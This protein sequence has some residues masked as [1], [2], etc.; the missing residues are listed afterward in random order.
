M[1]STTI[2]YDINAHIE[3]IK[4]EIITK[5]GNAIAVISFKNLGYG[6]ITAIKFNAIGYNS[7][8][9]IVSIGNREKFFL[10]IQDIIIKKNERTNNLKAKLPSFDIRKLVLEE[11]QICFADG[12]VA[13]YEGKN[14][15]DIELQEFDDE[16]PEELAAIHK[17]YDERIK[18]NICELDEGWICGCGRFNKSETTV[19]TLCGKA[20]VDTKNALS[21][22]GLK[23]LVDEY[24]AKIRAEQEEAKLRAIADK[25]ASKQR[26]IKIAIGV[27]LGVIILLSLNNAITMSERTTYS[28][29]AEMKAAVIG[30]YNYYSS[31]SSTSSS[32]Q[33]KIADNLVTERY[34]ILSTASDTKVT[35]RS[36]NPRK[37]TLETSRGTII[38]TSDG[39]LKYDGKLFKSG[40][41]W[42]DS[43]ETSPDSSYTYSS[44]N[45]YSDLAITVKTV[46]TNSGY[47]VCTGNV[48][49]N[50]RKTYYFVEVRGAFKDY[51]DNVLDT[52]WSY[53]V[54][55]EGLAPGES[56]TFRLSVARNPDITSC[57]VSLLDFD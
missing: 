56:S 34:Y 55:S 53:A 3:D 35:I 24:Q 1:K 30:T 9:D 33:L 18:Y 39:N 48:K 12:S 37:G 41:R 6:D 49:N 20:K 16:Q 51:S 23:N 27:I 38:V 54:G 5:G 22:A 8:G 50:G 7:F 32:H 4:C 19:C 46:S 29:E 45:G 57:T 14:I 52:D 10:I 28:S 40:G 44:N 47:T 43:S 17:I 13:T 36:W 2:N 21:T 11:A 25:K 15:K 42:S 26:K 31:S